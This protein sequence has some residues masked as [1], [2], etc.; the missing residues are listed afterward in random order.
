MIKLIVV[1]IFGGMLSLAVILSAVYVLGYVFG[2][3]FAQA[4]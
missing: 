1:T 3:G 2:L 4:I